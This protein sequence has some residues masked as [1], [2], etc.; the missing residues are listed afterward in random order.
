MQSNLMTADLRSTAFAAQSGGERRKFVSQ[1]LDVT[2]RQQR[3]GLR[4]LDDIERVGQRLQLELGSRR[5][6]A[7]ETVGSAENRSGIGFRSTDESGPT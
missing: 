1:L 4:A 3:A 6:T 7:I 2:E 5:E